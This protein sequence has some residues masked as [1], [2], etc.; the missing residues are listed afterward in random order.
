[1]R[2]LRIMHSAFVSCGLLLTTKSVGTRSVTSGPQ[3]IV[4]A[5]TNRSAKAS[6]PENIGKPKKRAK[7]L[8]KARETLI[9]LVP[10]AGDFPTLAE[11]DGAL[12]TT[13]LEAGIEGGEAAYVA[14]RAAHR[15]EKRLRKEKREK[16]RAS[17][18]LRD[19]VEVCTGK[20]CVQKN[21]AG[22]LLQAARS[23]G[24]AAVPCSCLGMCKQP[25]V[26]VRLNDDVFL[27][28]DFDEL[29][30]EANER[31]EGFPAGSTFAVI[32]A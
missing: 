32:E 22:G 11:I 21:G 14:A 19:V 8:V 27:V 7:C 2:Y 13:L 1:M 4:F 16:M 17:G 15:E 25:G 9:E 30:G 10:H 3:P 12:A 6:K 23:E 28:K 31:R 18:K 29:V 26:S 24:F 20:S 5:S